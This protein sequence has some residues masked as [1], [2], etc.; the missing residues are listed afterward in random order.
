M[1]RQTESFIELKLT[2]SSKILAF[3]SAKMAQLVNQATK[4]ARSTATVLITGESG[5]GKELISRLLHLASHRSKN[6]FVAINCA[7]LPEN[8]IES[9]L[10]GHERGAFTGAFQQQIGHFQQAHG[11]TLL[12]DEVSEMDISLQAKLLRAIEE[13]Q[14]QKVGSRNLEQVDARIIATSNKN[15]IESVMTKE[16]RSDLYYRLSVLKLNIPPLR[17]RREEIPFLVKHFVDQ[18]KQESSFRVRGIDQPGLEKLMEY[19][20]PGNV[21]QLRNVIHSA[22]VQAESEWITVDQ[23]DIPL[24]LEQMASTE[25]ANLADL[26]KQRIIFSLEKFA[27]NKKAAAAELGITPRTLS[28]KL[29]IYRAA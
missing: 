17:Q 18:F 1:S 11:G 15:L 28:N 4:F 5:T 27:G 10:F 13:Q 24:Q 21:R 3:N 29:K 2:G 9:E 26:E 25:T 7:A 16:F 8:L 14:I 12:L 23:L 6:N 19:S 20:W 22:C